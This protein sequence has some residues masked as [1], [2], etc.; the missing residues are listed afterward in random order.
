MS[1]SELAQAFLD[2]AA[3][4]D[5]DA[6]LGCMSTDVVM[7]E[8]QS[9]IHRGAEAVRRGM[10]S[11]PRI[12][13]QKISRETVEGNVVKMQGTLDAEGYGTVSTEWKFTIAG[14][15]ITRLDVWGG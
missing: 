15:K 9:G 3:R 7:D 2:A 4:R 6:M 5:V 11:W 1:P 10:A 8:P 14:D 13:N 12:S